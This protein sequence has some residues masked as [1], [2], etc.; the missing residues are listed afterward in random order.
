MSQEN[1]SD[2]VRN[3]QRQIAQ[4]IKFG[5][6][7]P[8]L[9]KSEGDEGSSDEEEV[10]SSPLRV[11][12]QVEAEPVDT[13]PKGASQDQEAGES[14][15]APQ[16]EAPSTPVKSP[17]SKQVLP[18]IGT[19]ESIDLDG[20]SQS[21][22]RLDNTAAKHKLS[23][24]P[25]NQR[26]SRKHHRY[27][28]DL[29]EVDIPG[30]QQ[31][32][33]DAAESQH[34]NAEE[35]TPPEKT[36]KQKLQEER[37]ESRRKREL[38]EQRHREEEED[39]KKKAEEWRLCEL[40]EERCCKQEE[41]R[42]LKKEEERRQREEMERRM[43]EEEERRQREEM[44]RRM[45][46][47]EERIEKEE[48][49][50]MREELELMQREEKE[51][52]LEE[53][54]KKKEEEER[55]RKEEEERKQCEPE[56]EPLRVDEEKS[57]TEAEEE[58]E[59][60]KKQVKKKR[61]LHAE[62]ERK[63]KEE[64]KRLC[65]EAAASSSDPERKRRAEEVRWREMEKRQRP[66]TFKGSSGEKQILL[67]KVNLT[68]VIPASSQQ[69]SAVTEHRDRAKASS[70]GG[71]DSPTLL[72]SQYVR[73]TAILVT[74]AQLC[75]TAVNLDH[76]KEITCKSLLGLA[77][78]KKAAMGTP[79]P[80]ESKTP[81]VRKSGKTKSL[82]ES[83]DQS[84]AAVLAEWAS[85]RCKI[86]KGAEEGK[87]EEY[88][89]PHNQSRH[90]S[91]DQSPF[92]HT[93][94]R[95]T[96]SA[97]AKFS[98]TPARNKFADSSRDSEVLNLEEKE[99]GSPASALSNIS[100]STSVPPAASPA[101]GSKA[102]SRGGKTVWIAAGKGECMFAKDL[103]S[104]I[105]PRSS[106]WSPRPEGSVTDAV[107]L[108]GESEDSDGREEGGEQGPPSPFGIKL[109][110]TNYSLRFRSD[111]STD[112]R[113][114][115]YSA[116]DSFNGVP[117]P[118]TP[119]DPD[120]DTS[121]FSDRSSPASPLRE[122][123]PGV[124]P[125][126][127]VVSLPKPRAKAG[128]SPTPS[129]HSEEEKPSK[130]SL[131]QRPS[132]SPKPATPPPSPLPKVGRGGSSDAVVQ[133]T[134]VGADS[135]GHEERDERREETSAVAQLH[136]NGQ[137]QGQ[138]GQ[139]EEEPKEKRSFFP[140]ISIPWREKADRKTELIRKE[141]KPSLQSRHSLDSVGVQDK[142]AGPPWITLALQKQK[143]FKEQQQ[144]RDERRSNRDAK[145]PEKQAKDKDSCVL[146]SPSE[147]KGSGNTSPP[148]SQ[149]PEE[150]KRPDTLLGCFERRDHLKKA[151]TLPSTVTVE[152]AD[153]TPSPPAVKEVTKRFPS[154]DSPQVSTEPAWLALAKRKAKAWSDCPQIIK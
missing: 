57:V 86:F 88:P 85:I 103:P 5:Q 102:Q 74:G 123:I 31:E 154:T 66:F 90:S 120:S 128:K 10:P 127:M 76:I 1:V 135:A 110:R 28:Q 139:G 13:E 34:R 40:E 89:D 84:S 111:Q 105:V 82:S 17:R 38:A 144:S 134:R 78:E 44:E 75:G 133:R 140:S 106:Q 95:K 98:I 67:Q 6:K 121:V 62:E 129:M 113:K 24:K 126:H 77:D 9:R 114:K 136:R 118:L 14:H 43:K 92:P 4:N 143:G 56:A 47:E 21:V 109:R 69:G 32:E 146:V 65:A 23:V 151:N 68:P 101:P 36:R 18:A 132:T 141:G 49:R 93:N 41:G 33:K 16:A 58:E 150:A 29:Q 7:P 81:P 27:T 72:S 64:E 147:G 39:R 124:K 83:T 70:L 145:L 51:R 138:G 20:V 50:R 71:A 91:E 87:F 52:T 60:M 2:K 108:G 12:A 55:S 142:E 137:G 8:S 26:I 48:E 125:G 152:I 99:G 63:K 119:I 53:E 15:G 46:E 107:S 148:K 131:Y 96:M 115:R 54:E 116:G 104:F 35:E 61:K 97:S 25:K 59:R 79:P 37:W 80:T 100:S 3:L 19:I 73:H 42:I 11:L 22:P 117:S 153:S 30:I 122:S 112:K 45:K 130:P 94:L 149:T